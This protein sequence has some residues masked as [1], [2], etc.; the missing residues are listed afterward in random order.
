MLFVPLRLLWNLIR[1]PWVL[2]RALFSL[3][4]S[5]AEVLHVEVASD[6]SL[7]AAP[8]P[9]WRRW[10]SAKSPAF[11]SIAVLDAFSRALKKREPR[12]RVILVEWNALAS[13]WATAWELRAQILKWKELAQVVVYFPES[14]GNKDLYVASAAHRIY[15]HPAATLALN[16]VSAQLWSA[17]D[18]LSRLGVEVE[19]YRR[20]EYKS[21]AEGLTETHPSAASLEQT[22]ELVQ[23][24]ESELERALGER[25]GDAAKVA[26]WL[27]GAFFSAEAAQKCGILDGVAYRDELPK[28]LAAEPARI[29][30]GLAHLAFLRRRWFLPVLRAPYVAVANIQGTIGSRDAANGSGEQRLLQHLRD[31]PRASAVVLHVNSPGG[32]AFVSDELHHAVARLA[33]VKPVF[34][35]FGDVSASGGYYLSAGVRIHSAPLTVTGSIGVIAMRP[36][37][38]NGLSRWGVRSHTVKTAP[39]SDLLS[40]TRAFAPDERELF[41]GHVDSMYQRFLHIVSAGRKLTIERAG[42]LAKG[43]VYLAAKALENGLVDDISGFAGLVQSLAAYKKLAMIVVPAPRAAASPWSIEKNPPKKME[44]WCLAEVPTLS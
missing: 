7:F 19:V 17:K 26:E 2:L 43:R 18:L 13:G 5:H 35:I 42:E 3:F 39:Y 22:R 38:E 20:A 4:A 30:N 32:S 6:L 31:D 14:A 33:E 40:T 23:G 36:V 34:A 9:F 8:V 37:R 10:V 29:I 1:F 24:I 21:A 27:K 15:A 16:G 11:D 44:L 28:L 12:P 41:E 25:C